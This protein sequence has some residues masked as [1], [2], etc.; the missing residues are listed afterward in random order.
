MLRWEKSRSVL[1]TWQEAADCQSLVEV[2]TVL[3]LF[4]ETKSSQGKHEILHIL[5]A[6]V[7]ET[8]IIFIGGAG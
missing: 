7:K 4:M 3:E 8:R 2:S 5:I 1:E 6:A